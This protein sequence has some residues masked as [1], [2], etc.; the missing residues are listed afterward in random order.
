MRFVL[1]SES[2]LANGFPYCYL[3]LPLAIR[4][5]VTNHV[6]ADNCYDAVVSHLERVDRAIVK[7]P[8]MG[9]WSIGLN[10]CGKVGRGWLKEQRFVSRVFASTV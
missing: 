4:A 8:E 9:L 2:V 3:L 6:D 5:S 7:V 1:L 10:Q